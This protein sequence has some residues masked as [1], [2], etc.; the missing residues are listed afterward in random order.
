[1]PA[2]E[3]AGQKQAVDMIK[4]GAIGTLREIHNW[5]MRPMWP[6]FPTLPTD[7]PSVPAGFDWSLWLGPSLDRPY[8]PNYTHTNFRGW[9]EFGGGSIAD[10]GHYSLWPIFQLLDLE[11]PISVESTPSHVCTVS[12]EVCQ[13]IKNDYSFPAACTIRM[14]F[15]PKGERAA[16]DIFWYD[17][18]IKPP[19]PDELMAENEEM[20]EEGMMFVGDKGKILGGF[21]SEYPQLLPEARMR[22]YRTAN[23]LP[24][25]AP[26]QRLGGGRQG[27]DPSARNAAWITAFKGG[28]AS[29]GD[30]TLA[31]PISDAMNLAAISLRLGGR[32][33]LFDSAGAKITNIPGA[34]RF[35]TRDYRPGWE[36]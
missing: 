13:R 23:N 35:L 33:L 27:G 20:P 10:M 26:R 4:N 16:L 3:G 7:T 1:M 30:F 25:P 6:Q 2:S 12:D 36:L 32:R 17:G 29:Y 11:S 24:E 9:Y 34:N 19:V 18:G 15:A 21:R 5:S 22:A 8:H 31:G 14:R 28:P